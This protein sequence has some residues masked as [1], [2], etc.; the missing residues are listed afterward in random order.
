MTIIAGALRNAEDFAAEFDALLKRGYAWLNFTL[1]GV[2]EGQLVVV[3]E[4]P[5]T[6]GQPGRPTSVNY[7][8]FCQGVLANNGV[9]DVRVQAPQG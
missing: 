3:L 7:S 5:S 1:E 6:V 2:Y 8:G 4:T 9:L